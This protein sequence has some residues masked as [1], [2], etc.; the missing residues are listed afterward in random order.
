MSGVTILGSLNVDLLTEV[1]HLPRRGE[2]VS[3]RSVGRLP[4]GKGA[5]QAVACARAGARVR[6]VGACGTDEVGDLLVSTLKEEGIDVRDVHRAAGSTTG[7]ATI[8]VDS[9]GENMIVLSPGANDHVGAEQVDAACSDLA[10]GDVLLMQLEIPVA[11]VRLAAERAHR[12]GATVVLNA[13][14]V[15]PDLDDLLS[16]VD[17]LVVN[18]HEA[19]QLAAGVAPSDASAAE[20]APL[21][22]EQ[23][24]CLVVATL[25]PDGAL[26]TRGERPARTEAPAVTV[27]DTV[28]AGDA[29][30][31]YL[32][33]ALSRG[34]D[35][36]TAI[37]DAVRA[38][39]IAVA[40]P[41]AQ[42]SI[43]LRAELSKP[44]GGA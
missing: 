18:E 24:G 22:A 26:S 33:A 1:P 3:G 10:A 12:R 27:K 41:G 29:F 36:P 15:R 43:P 14:P 5:N 35:E 7:T 34:T 44:I 19:I 39:S 40:R 31:G 37:A 23:H 17:V 6:M 28:G 8:F 32:A 11:T 25:G 13:A 4:G 16:L 30:T 42:A 38:A 21:L 2:T 20:C 9:A